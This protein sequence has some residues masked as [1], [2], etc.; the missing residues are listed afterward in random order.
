[1]F[2]PH[3][4]KHG[5]GGFTKNS[6]CYLYLSGEEKRVDD[7]GVELLVVYV[8]F[9]FFSFSLFFFFFH[10]QGVSGLLARL[11]PCDP[12]EKAL[13]LGRSS[14]RQDSKSGK[15]GLKRRLLP[16]ELTQEGR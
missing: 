9:L 12:R 1:M 7:V 2:S 10:T 16:E 13:P 3:A 4:E 5:E 11:I 15:R 6:V 14:P 8:C